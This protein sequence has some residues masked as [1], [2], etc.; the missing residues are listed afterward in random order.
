[1]KKTTKI[2][3]KGL[4]SGL[5]SLLGKETNSG[6]N[7]IKQNIDNNYKMIPIEFITPGPWQP[8]KIFDEKNIKHLSESIKKQGIIQPVVLKSK[9]NTQNQ[10]FLFFF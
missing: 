10:Y 9:N 2:Q 3:K 1:M 4:G 8:R 6:S 7:L 5:S